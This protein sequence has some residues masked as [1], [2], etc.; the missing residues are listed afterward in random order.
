MGIIL[1]AWEI[2]SIFLPDIDISY[3]TF[4]DQSDLNMFTTIIFLYNLIPILLHLLLAVIFVLYFYNISYH[5]NRKSLL[6]PILFLI[7]NIINL[8]FLIV[9]YSIILSI[10]D[11]ET[12]ELFEILEM[13]E[14][15]ENLIDVEIIVNIIACSILVVGFTFVFIYSIY[16]NNIMLVMFCSLYFAS[17]LITLFRIL[18]NALIE[19]YPG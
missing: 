1:L 19:F 6:G 16:T 17:L 2:I 9:S 8:C 7:G 10:Y 4:P 13:I 5:Y 15:L 14:R 12:L 11:F 18:N 3:S